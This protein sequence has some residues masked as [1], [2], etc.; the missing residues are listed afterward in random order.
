MSPKVMFFFDAGLYPAVGKDA[1][2]GKLG[3]LDA[4]MAGL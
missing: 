3:F 1:V 2:G 4:Q